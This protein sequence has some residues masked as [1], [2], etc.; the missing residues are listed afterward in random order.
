MS[1]RMVAVLL[2]RTYV[3]AS[4]FHIH[5][6]LFLF[7]LKI[8]GCKQAG[9]RFGASLYTLLEHIVCIQIVFHCSTIIPLFW[10]N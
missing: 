5:A 6:S 7:A 9:L 2:S 3:F 4:R 1:F 10:N 8:S